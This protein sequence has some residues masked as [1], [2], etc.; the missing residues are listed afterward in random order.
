MVGFILKWTWGYVTITQAILFC[1]GTYVAGRYVGITPPWKTS[2]PPDASFNNPNGLSNPTSSNINTIC[3]PQSD[4]GIGDDEPSSRSI[5]RLKI[6]S[7]YSQDYFTRA[8]TS[9]K[10]AIGDNEVGNS[11]FQ[12]NG[13]VFDATLSKTNNVAAYPYRNKLTDETLCFFMSADKYDV[14]GDVDTFIYKQ[15]QLGVISWGTPF[16]MADFSTLSNPALMPMNN[17]KYKKNNYTTSGG[18]VEYPS[19][20]YFVNNI[21]YIWCGANNPQI[22]YDSTTSRFQLAN[23]HSNV[24]YTN[25][26]APSDFKDSVEAGNQCARINIAFAD[27]THTS[28][29]NNVDDDQN[30]TQKYWHFDRQSGIFI[31]KIWLPKSSD[32][33]PP[34]N[35]NPLSYWS[36]DSM[37]ATEN[38]RQEII[39]DLIEA[40]EDNYE[41]CLLSKMGF[42][43]EQLMPRYGNQDVRYN[44]STYNNP[45]P[46]IIGQGVKPF[47]TNCLIDSA[48]D[49]NM[50]VKY[51]DPQGIDPSNNGSLLYSL[52]FLNNQPVNLEAT[53]AILVAE[54]MPDLISASY[55]KIA[56]DLVPT[57]YYD[58][59]ATASNTIFI[60]LKN[61]LS[62]NYAY[63]SGGVSVPVY[64]PRTVTT[65]NIEIRNGGTGRLAKVGKDSSVIFQVLRN[66]TVPNLLS[67]AQE[68]QPSG[69]DKEDE[70]IDR[71]IK[72]VEKQEKIINSLL[73]IS[74]RRLE[75]GNQP[76]QAPTA[77]DDTE[78]KQPDVPSG[79]GSKTDGDDEEKQPEK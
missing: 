16:S 31:H 48:V 68:Q 64:S 21:N 58:T 4:T 6:Y 39:N 1:P 54:S 62:G 63:A 14:G 79:G 57:Q 52:G 29:N 70:K 18:T 10:N 51:A 11:L 26:D 33:S 43:Y 49:I 67:A 30:Y 45:N 32:W 23:L 74:R 28:H 76:S 35:I 36:N 2:Y 40:D 42:K 19:E 41:S 56:T 8:N 15:Y 78:E 71:L 55:Y 5:G 38:N 46:N 24:F 59:G 25:D 60:C 44:E 20:A 7:R 9:I 47:M 3:P 65:I 53:T 72:V 13:N 77:P 69:E 27:N 17:N 12:V 66:I 75:D 22:K 37:D 61:Y 34:E 50:N 73:K